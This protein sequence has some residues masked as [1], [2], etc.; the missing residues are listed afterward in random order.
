[1]GGASG[2]G[3]ATARMVVDRGGRVILMGRS[4]ERLKA[5]REELGPAALSIPLDV[6]DENAVRRAFT[7]IERIDHLITAAAGTLRGRLIDL[8]TQ[9]ARELFET[10][11]WGGTTASNMPLPRWSRTDRW[12]SFQAGSVASPPSTAGLEVIE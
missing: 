5:A 8:Q 12:C 7:G 9:R 4:P 3:L 1:T 2:I 10:K 11:F 6:T